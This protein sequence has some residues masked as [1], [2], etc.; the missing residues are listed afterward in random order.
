MSPMSA[1]SSSI[2]TQLLAT[3]QQYSSLFT[4]FCLFF[5]LIVNFAANFVTSSRQQP[6]ACTLSGNKPN[7]ARF[8]PIY[9]S[10]HCQSISRTINSLLP[11]FVVVVLTGLVLQ[12][13]HCQCQPSVTYHRQYRQYQPYQQSFSRHN[14][15][16]QS[17]RP[18]YDN[19]RFSSHFNGR[20]FVTANSSTRTGS[21]YSSS[22]NIPDTI[23]ANTDNFQ[24]GKWEYLSL[25][26]IL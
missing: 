18:H 10:S 22:I 25:E 3:L 6:T 17:Y 4:T 11:L 12:G 16:T 5:Y 14:G 8:Q 23:N 9:L 13:P 24:N 26:F 15:S 20:P 19:H 7:R 2:T 1:F 21:F